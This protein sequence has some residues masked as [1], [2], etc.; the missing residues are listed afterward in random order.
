LYIRYII[1]EVMSKPKTV[2][3][4]FLG[5]KNSPAQLNGKPLT[6]NTI[7][8]VPEAYKRFNWWQP[9][10]QKQAQEPQE[11]V[12][13]PKEFKIP[14]EAEEAFQDEIGRVQPEETKV[15]EAAAPL[16][17]DTPKSVTD[18]ENMKKADLVSLIEGLGGE[19]D[20]GMLKA[21]LVQAAA[22]KLGLQ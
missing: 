2:K 14:E 18:L 13:E 9:I 22:A 4:K 10:D 19:A 1:G 16:E 7:Y 17:A 20:M 8:E 3:M 15:P 12:Q 21:V 6:K 5:G 11:D